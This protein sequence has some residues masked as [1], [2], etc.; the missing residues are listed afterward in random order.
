MEPSL[1]NEI[2]KAVTKTLKHSTNN[3][4]ADA[5]DDDTIRAIAKAI[6]EALEVYDDSKHQ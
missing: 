3:N 1:K 6:V 2:S 4:A 5:F